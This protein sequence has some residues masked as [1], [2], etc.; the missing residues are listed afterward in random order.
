[1]NP[2]EFENSALLSA[3]E[4]F[5]IEENPEN[6]ANFVAELKAA[7]FLAPVNFSQAP[8]TNDDG[9]VAL[10]ENTET[11]LVALQTEEGQSVF[12]IFTDMEAMAAGD[13]AADEDLYTWPM[14]LEEYLPVVNQAGDEL[15]GLALN[16]F[17]NGMPISRENLNYLFADRTHSPQPGGQTAAQGSED[18]ELDIQDTDDK[19]LPTPLM[20]ELIGIADDSYGEIQTMYLLWLTN[21]KTKV[22]NYLLV[23]DGPD[24]EKLRAF[25]PEFA[26]AFGNFAPEGKSAVDMI[27]QSDL[28]LDLTEFRAKYTRNL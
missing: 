7:T 13:M 11:R 18:A 22:A 4:Q 28:G 25:F 6:E 26:R 8:I 17:T 24:A 10:A 23:I 9:S 20:A 19:S 27:L 21:N 16:P 5:R 14:T 15:A 1:M 2:E 3:L 12:P